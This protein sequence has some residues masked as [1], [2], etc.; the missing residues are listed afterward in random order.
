MTVFI[1]PS[2]S[3]QI[4]HLNEIFEQYFPGNSKGIFVEVGANDGYSWSNTWALAEIGWRGLYLEPVA[5]LA[6]ECERR[7]AHNN[8]KVI[9]AAAG[10]CNGTTRLYL[11]EGCTTSPKVA[12][13][14]TFHY[15]N[16]PNNFRIVPVVSLN[17]IL[18]QQEIPVDFELLVI[19]V[20]GDELGVLDGLDLDIWQPKIIIIETSNGN[21]NLGWDFNAQGIDNRLKTLYSEM[22]HDH[23]NSVYARKAE[24]GRG[25]PK[26]MT[27]LFESKWRMLL[28]Y[29]G[30]YSCVNFVETGTGHGDTL[31]IL[32]PFFQRCHSVELSPELYQDVK[33]RFGHIP[34][35]TLHRGDSGDVLKKI[36][37]SLKG[38][39][40]FYLDAHYSGM[41]TACI[42]GTETPIL[43]ELNAIL[44]HPLNGVIVI[45]DLKSFNGN[46]GY[47]TPDELKRYVNTIRQGLQFE[48]ILDG[49][50]MMVITPANKKPIKEKKLVQVVQKVA[51]GEAQPEA[52]AHDFGRPPVLYGPNR[53]PTKG[54]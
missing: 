9:R 4:P 15:G 49:G 1:R 53:N 11:G 20:D 46:C 43:D 23:I 13:E 2:L 27:S 51:T 6:F 22:Y 41:G 25:N 28:R 38:P 31:D 34:T 47:P 5:K 3:C 39:A 12:R 35:I 33:A 21:P 50:G 8:V 19:D 7:H 10:M 45:D 37:S 32:Y 44:S 17:S 52:K 30:E 16:S 42:S 54:K 36:F 48:S 18:K 24:T 14:N 40:L 29:G 26:T